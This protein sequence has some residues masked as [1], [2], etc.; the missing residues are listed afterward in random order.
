[1]LCGQQVGL[2]IRQNSLDLNLATQEQSKSG[3]VSKPSLNVDV[4][5]FAGDFENLKLLSS[6]LEK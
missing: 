2:N 3:C 6:N 4:S 1:M 5:Y